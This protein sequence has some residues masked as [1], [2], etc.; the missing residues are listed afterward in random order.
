VTVYVTVAF[1][2]GP[3]DGEQWPMGD[4]PAV[5]DAGTV[6]LEPLAP[7]GDPILVSGRASPAPPSG[8]APRPYHR[9]RREAEPNRWGHLLWTYHYDYMGGA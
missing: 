5:I 1:H 2:G 4:P 9:H 3:Y 7:G 8:A 6:W